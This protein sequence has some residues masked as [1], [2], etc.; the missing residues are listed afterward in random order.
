MED[1]I[2]LTDDQW[3]RIKK[4]SPHFET[5]RRDYI[6]NCPRWITEQVI[7]VYEEATGKTINRK[8]I[9]CATC[10]LRLFQNIGKLYFW[11]KE[12]REGLEKAEQNI[13]KNVENNNTEVA[14]E[15]APADDESKNK[16]NEKKDAE[17]GDNEAEVSEP[18]SG[19]KKKNKRSSK[20]DTGVVAKV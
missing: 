3:Q 2:I 15:E 16:D 8:N 7:S 13:D 10:I 12:Y 5:A 6:R 9:T 1:R 19:D 20:K 14:Q 4:A 17:S 18:D 11:N